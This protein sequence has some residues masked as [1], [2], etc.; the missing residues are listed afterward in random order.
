MRKTGRVTTLVSVLLI[1][2]D[3]RQFLDH[4]TMNIIVSTYKN[5]ER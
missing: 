2:Y 4:Y 1:C 3:Q 5:L